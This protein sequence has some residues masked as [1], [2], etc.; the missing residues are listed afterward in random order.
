MSTSLEYA[1]GD[2]ISYRDSSID[3]DVVHLGIITALTNSIIDIFTFTKEGVDE[4]HLKMVILKCECQQ[5]YAPADIV[6]CEIILVLPSRFYTSGV[7]ADLHINQLNKLP[8]FEGIED[9]YTIIDVPIDLVKYFEIPSFYGSE[10]INHKRAVNPE[11]L[12]GLISIPIQFQSR[13]FSRYRNRCY[14]ILQFYEAIRKY[15]RVGWR[16]NACKISFICLP[17]DFLKWLITTLSNFASYTYSVK[18][19]KTSHYSYGVVQHDY[20]MVVA[21]TV[22]VSTEFSI[23][24][25]AKLLIPVLGVGCF[26]QICPGHGGKRASETAINYVDGD[27]KFIINVLEG[28]VKIFCPVRKEAFG[29]PEIIC[30]SPVIFSHALKDK[31]EVGFIYKSK[32]NDLMRVKITSVRSDYYFF[33]RRDKHVRSIPIRSYCG[34]IIRMTCR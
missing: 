12:L 5:T 33:R 25:S 27:V 28:S 14:F 2:C 9:I 23:S 4:D 24:V 22:F 34:T 11:Q 26:R 7:G 15:K 17:T 32:V 6:L 21:D 30:P 8:C 19:A 10:D 3:L 16:N 20:G 13:A 1:V 29:L 18:K 31:A